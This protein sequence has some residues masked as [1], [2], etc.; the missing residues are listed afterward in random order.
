MH[1]SHGPS[2][3]RRRIRVHARAEGFS[4]IELMVTLVILAIV[5]AL[6]VPN[7]TSVVNSNRLS[8]QANELVADI[9]LARSEA[10]RRNRT[11]RLCR[12]TNGTAC[13][14]GTGQWTGWI[15][16][17]TGGANPEML[18]STVVKAPIKVSGGSTVD[19]RADGLARNPTGGLLNT[20]FVICS[21]NPR[22]AEN[23][24]QVELASGSRVQVTAAAHTT[25]G[26]CP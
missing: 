17:L 22:P 4:L 25:P 21:P 18:R 11:V 14:T 24:R 15:V 7:F 3:R 23:L 5:S 8:A 9:Q 12:S 6:A 20:T 26:E 13:A 2:C 16:T 19:F 10:L 1:P